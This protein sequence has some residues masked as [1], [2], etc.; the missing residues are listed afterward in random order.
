MV[1]ILTVLA[2]NTDPC[3]TDKHWMLIMLFINQNSDQLV[4]LDLQEIAV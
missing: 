1:D 3:I 2:C 4:L